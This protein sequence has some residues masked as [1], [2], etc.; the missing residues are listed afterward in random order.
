VTRQ[1]GDRQDVPHPGTTTATYVTVNPVTDRT[2]SFGT[3]GLICNMPGIMN[4]L[5]P[6]LIGG[7]AFTFSNPNA[8]GCTASVELVDR[9]TAAAIKSWNTPPLT[10][11]T[12]VWTANIAFDSV[13]NTLDLSHTY[14]VEMYLYRPKSNSNCNPTAYAAYLEK[15]F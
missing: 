11:Y 5:D 1:P 8:S 10:S 14:D 13:V 7:L 4:G 3:I 12:G 2:Y 6:N 15:V 9:T